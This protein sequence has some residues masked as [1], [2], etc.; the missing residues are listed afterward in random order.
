MMVPPRKLY[1]S[2]PG[3]RQALLRPV[4]LFLVLVISSTGCMA[5]L[6]TATSSV[7]A[8]DKRCQRCHA[9]IYERY[10]KT[11]MANA[12]GL[13]ED[14]V[15]SGAFHHSPSGVDYTIDKNS[16]QVTLH[17]E[18]HRG[19]PDTLSG[20]HRLDYFLGSGHLGITYLYSKNHYLFESP[21]A[22]YK[23]LQGY[24][25]KPGLETERRMAPDLAMDDTCLRCHMS[26]V[27]KPDLGTANHYSG[28]PFQHT[29]IVCE[30]C[31]GDTDR[32][33]ATGG[34]S[35]VVNPAKLPAMR[36]DSVC[37]VCHLEGDT[38]VTRKGKSILDYRPG[39]D[40]RDFQSYFV[41]ARAAN[42]S[43]SVSEIEQFNASRCRMA[44][45]DRMSCLT[46]HEMH[47]PPSESERVNYYRS[48][49]LSCHTGARFASQ[50]H[51]DVPD[52]TSCHM[53]KTGAQNV[54][55][56]AWTDHR[57]RKMPEQLDNRLFQEMESTPLVSILPDGSNERD[58][59]LG[60]YDLVAQGDR[61]R[62]GIAKQILSESSATDPSDV[63]VLLALGVMAQIERRLDDA[64]KFYQKILQI[65]PVQLNALTNL[66]TL[67]AKEGKLKLSEQL[68]SSAF[69]R[70]EDQSLLG[71]N[72][73]T[74]ECMLGEREAAEKTL[75]RA[76]EYGADTPELVQT[77]S[78][79][80][81]G[82]QPCIAVVK[83]F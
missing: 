14:R 41:F 46:C 82:Q 68:L 9:Q 4:M 51:A 34:R 60:Y 48:K 33:V 67:E 73:A 43:R 74:V 64:E 3:I 10:L 53:P 47:S 32:H 15:S 26:G 31:H 57:I 11:Y 19:A 66:G 8:A 5:A 65:E 29:G 6:P 12:S 72:L 28:E 54:Q 20:T 25:M 18:V 61:S 35:A 83:G 78:A 70:N 52:C 80:Q 17:Y 49:C 22:Y 45:G 30:S 55:H 13:A 21:I 71:K 81:S 59:G 44:S 56:V 62:I 36:R 69:E 23:A 75:R 79:I 76:L 42:T 77:L 50:H 27:V 2:I 40:I 58:L 1:L 7:A 16:D 39:D 24:A 37:I 38:R 63:P